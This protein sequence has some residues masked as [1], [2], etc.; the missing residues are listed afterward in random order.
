MEKDYSRNGFALTKHTLEE[1][2]LNYVT[3]YGCSFG[4]DTPKAYFIEV[5]ETML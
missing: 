5:F 4:K 1:E 3:D 2:K